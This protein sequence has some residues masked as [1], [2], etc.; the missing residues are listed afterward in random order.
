MEK[1]CLCFM[2][3]PKRNFS[4][5]I[6]KNFVLILIVIKCG[7]DTKGDLKIGYEGNLRDDGSLY[8]YKASSKRTRLSSD[9]VATC[10]GGTSLFESKMDVDKKLIPNINPDAGMV[11]GLGVGVSVT[12]SAATQAWL[13]KCAGKSQ[14]PPGDA[15]SLDQHFN[16]STAA[17]AGSC[18][19]CR[20]FFFCDV[21]TNISWLVTFS[22]T[23]V[24]SMAFSEQPQL[25]TTSEV[26]LSVLYFLIAPPI[27]SHLPLVTF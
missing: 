3:Y 25:A 10:E 18:P 6:L 24:L 12:P 22:L 2:K 19:V 1:V 14:P 9:F 23:R 17:V 15:C 11:R 4:C 27:L 8:G 13:L 21:F 26:I 20:Y 5:F 7:S 16:K